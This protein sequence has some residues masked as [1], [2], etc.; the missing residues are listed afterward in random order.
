MR[1]LNTD[2]ILSAAKYLKRDLGGDLVVLVK[3]SERFVR[4]VRPRGAL[5]EIK[6]VFNI[7]GDLVVY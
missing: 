6:C 2:P 3:I 7:S 4:L 5:G 1:V